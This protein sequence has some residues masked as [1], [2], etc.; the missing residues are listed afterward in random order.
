V[1]LDL[2]LFKDIVPSKFKRNARS[3]LN[4]KKANLIKQLLNTKMPYKGAVSINQAD[5]GVS[6]EAEGIETDVD[7]EDPGSAH[8]Q[9]NAG[10]H[11]GFLKPALRIPVYV[12]RGQ[13]ER[14]KYLDF[15]A[16]DGSSSGGVQVF[17]GDVALIA[18]YD[19][20][21]EKDTLNYLVGLLTEAKGIAPSKYTPKA[22]RWS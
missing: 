20:G 11:I 21:S 16:G 3:T 5:S 8:S 9:S 12:H 13:K 4:D 17:F 22:G 7:L 1:E 2:T 14:S 18:S 6:N 15:E 10:I 19:R